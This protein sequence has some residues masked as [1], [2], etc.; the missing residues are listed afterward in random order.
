MDKKMGL[1]GEGEC[2]A[3][4]VLSMAISLARVSNREDTEACICRKKE[5]LYRPSMLVTVPSKTIWG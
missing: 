4:V 5:M 1:L 3:N 2:T